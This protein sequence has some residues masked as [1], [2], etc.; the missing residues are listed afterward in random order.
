MNIIPLKLTQF[1]ILTID[2][3]HSSFCW[4]HKMRF[5]TYFFFREAKCLHFP[6]NIKWFSGPI[7]YSIDVF[8]LLFDGDSDNGRYGLFDNASTISILMQMFYFM[9]VLRE[10]Y[11][12]VYLLHDDE[13]A[14][15]VKYLC[16]AT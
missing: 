8:M 14:T 15:I 1:S 9:V 6:R 2:G 7:F 10:Q 11:Y 16:F 13:E 4:F 3:V 5:I 12:R